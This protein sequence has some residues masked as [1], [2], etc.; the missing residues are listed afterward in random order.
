MNTIMESAVIVALITSAVSLW[1]NLR[2]STQKHITSERSVWRNEIRKIGEQIGKTD[3][4]GLKTLLDRLKLRINAY[5]KNSEGDYIHDSHLWETINSLKSSTESMIPYLKE[6]L[7]E[8]LSLLLKYD[9]ERAKTEVRGRIY[10]IA[11]Y[12]SIFCGD[13]YMIYVAMRK[14]AI[15]GEEIAC[16][17]MII[18]TLYCEEECVH[19][20]IRSYIK[21]GFKKDDNASKEV[22][23]GK[24]IRI[25]QSI[26]A[27][28]I[29]FALFAF[30][31]LGTSWPLYGFSFVRNLSAGF[32]ALSG[33][34]FIIGITLVMIEGIRKDCTFIKYTY[35]V[36][37]LMIK[38]K[39]I[40]AMTNQ[41]TAKE[42]DIVQGE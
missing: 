9:W 21:S 10:I 39:Y 17:F 4:Q 38:K 5:G 14:Q 42:G 23:K 20:C 26:F 7:V 29:I 33:Y 12:G 2:S 25:G 36:H 8:M 31:L 24:R 16:A 40:E 6:C 27:H 32:N 1:T 3:G 19:Y 35:A 13:I 22:K 30:L 11:G 15:I 37:E 28:L 18:F 34:L 41:Q